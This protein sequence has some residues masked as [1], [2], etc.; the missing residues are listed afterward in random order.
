MARIIQRGTFGGGG[1]MQSGGNSPLFRAQQALSQNQPALAEQICRRRLER[2]PDDMNMRLL[3]AQALLQQQQNEE[4]AEQAQRVVDAQPNNANAQ[5]VLSGALAQI[6]SKSA[7]ERAEAAAR[8]ASALLPR[9]AQPRVQLAEVYLARRKLSEAR[10]AADEAVKLEPTLASGHL[11]RAVVMLQDSDP[12]GAADEARQAIRYDKAMGPA[13]YW[14][15]LSLN[16]LK[17]PKEA[18][19]ALD[20]AVELNVPVPPAQVLGLRGQIYVKQRSWRNYEWFKKATMAYAAAQGASGRPRFIALPLGV[21]I[22]FFSAFGKWAPAAIAVV[23]GAILLGLYAI[24]V[25]GNWIV[26]AVLLAL[27]IGLIFGFVRS[28]ESGAIA[29]GRFANTLG[30]VGICVIIL[31]VV[32]GATF[33]AIWVPANSLAHHGDL[34]RVPVG[35]GVGALFGAVTTAW[36]GWSLFKAL[37]TLNA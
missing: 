21:L 28:V 17:Q 27:V 2:K 24:P 29:L 30:L 3:L 15:A 18:E 32:G 4:A 14:L 23:A 16:Q 37:R 9:K 12:Q 20:R 25:A 8:K 5:V 19:S 26:A 35:V 11:I 6:Q 7:L 31:L 22:T 13:H 36:V 1:G 34:W 10:A 33:L